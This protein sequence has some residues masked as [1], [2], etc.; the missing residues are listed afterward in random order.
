M[1]RLYVAATG[2]AANTYVLTGEGGESL[3]LDAGA[4]IRKVLPHVGD[5]RKICACLITHEHADHARAWREYAYR[6]IPIYTGGGTRKAITGGSERDAMHI[7]RL[8]S[9]Q[10]AR[11]GPFTIK[12]FDVQHDAVEPL[13]FM[14]RYNPTGETLVYATDTYYLKYTFPGMNYWI[15]ECNYCENLIDH[16]T[17]PALRRRL[18]ESH[19]S[20]RRLMDALSANDLAETMK[21]VLVHLSDQRSDEQRMVSE[22]QDLTGI[23]TIAA[24]AETE[25]LLKQ[26]P[27]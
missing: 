16:E 22:I 1:M 18:K 6:G 27:F 13:G 9:M 10:T 8:R 21:I 20:L 26:T 11:R 5:V 24:S 15:V 3:I 19:M 12:A 2:S 4:P 17:D 7:V 25:I 23:E 14:I